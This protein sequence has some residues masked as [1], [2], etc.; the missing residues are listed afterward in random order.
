MAEQTGAGSGRT[1]RKTVDDIRREIDAEFPPSFDDVRLEETEAVGA[2]RAPRRKP[3]L[4]PYLKAA[5]FG[6]IVV[7]VFMLGYLAGRRYGVE[8]FGSLPALTSGHSKPV[9]PAASVLSASP[10][11]VIALD[12]PS[13]PVAV[14]PGGPV[15]ADVSGGVAAET[16]VRVEPRD[17]R[18]MPRT[19]TPRPETAARAPQPAAPVPLN[20][21]G[22]G[23]WVES[24][25]QLRTALRQWLAQSGQAGPNTDAEDAEV[26][27]GADGRTAKTRVSVRVGGHAI[28]REQRWRRDPGGWNI[29]E[30]HQVRFPPNR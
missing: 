20:L 14:D 22:P 13:N 17:R 16:R 15:G 1:S 18:V 28:I 2:L 7:E 25:S 26:V 30:E 19:P 21:P 27:L 24:Q 8:R 6:T 12:A 4:R 23:D 29:V 10:V 3:K 11:G 5:V 9:R